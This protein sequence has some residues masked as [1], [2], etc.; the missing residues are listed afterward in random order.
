[1]KDMGYSKGYVYDPDTET[2]FFGAGLFFLKEWNG[3]S[4]YRPKGDGTEAEIK[5]RLD[6]WDAERTKKGKS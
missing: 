2:G 5:K 1:M 4:F 3:A 6:A